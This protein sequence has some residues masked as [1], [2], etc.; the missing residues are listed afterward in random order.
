MTYSNF[1]SCRITGF[2]DKKSNFNHAFFAQCSF[3]EAQFN[4]SSFQGVEFFQ[5][6]LHDL[7]FSTS[8]IDGIIVSESKKELVGIIVNAAQAID[9]ARMYGVVIK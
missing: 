6:P 9:I 1:T 7:D 8:N 3:E 5:T 2:K 4:Q